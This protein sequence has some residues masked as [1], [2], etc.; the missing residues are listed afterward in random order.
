MGSK[1]ERIKAILEE[2]EEKPGWEDISDKIKADVLCIN[3][4][5]LIYLFYENNEFGIIDLNGFSF[6]GGANNNFRIESHYA[7]SSLH[8]NGGL[9]TWFKIY[10][11][12]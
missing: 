5:S 8:G 7:S 6:M 9:I 4:H 10:K 12:N 11:R 2:P 1:L 3:G